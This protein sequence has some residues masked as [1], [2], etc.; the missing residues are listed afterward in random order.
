MVGALVVQ[1]REEMGLSQYELAKRAGLP[2]G[3]LSK[4][5]GGE[6]ALPRRPTRDKLGRVLK[7]SEGDF[8]R[9]AGVLPAEDGGKPLGEPVTTNNPTS[10]PLSIPSLFSIVDQLDEVRVIRLD[11][12][13]SAGP[14]DAIPQ[15]VEYRA[16]IPGRKR[17]TPLY[18]V[19][20]TGTCM[21]P[22][23]LPGDE[24][25]FDAERPAEPG[26]TVV[27]VIDN[28]DAVVKRLVEDKGARFLLSED[29]NHRIP[30]DERVRIVGVVVLS[31]HR[32]L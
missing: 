28:E 18:A 23:I 12:L 2:Q 9:A 32:F 8:F 22:I 14:G 24:V 27:A 11:Q 15:G 3:H 21:E 25:L 20:A 13:V 17:R 7:L 31:Q 29:G 5:E 26:H 16:R 10:P 1:R 4:I 30:V 19:T 6:F